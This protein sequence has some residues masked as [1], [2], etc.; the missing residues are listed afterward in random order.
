ME[1]MIPEPLKRKHEELHDE[2][3]KVTKEGGA[4]GDAAKIVATLMHPHFAKEDAYAL[5]PLGLL[6]LV[7]KGSVKPDMA[8]VS[9]LTDQLQHDLGQM[10]AEHHAIVAALRKLG[11]S[12]RRENKPEYVTFVKN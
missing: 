9:K 2:L 7:A 6:P 10:L 3:R 4:V 5:P 1:F 11:D 8:E 12:A